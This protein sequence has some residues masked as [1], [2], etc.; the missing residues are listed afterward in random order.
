MTILQ[1]DPSLWRSELPAI[2]PKGHKYGRGIAVIYGAPK[3]TGA[4]RLAARA[5]ARIGAGLVKVIAPEGTGE[6]YRSTLSEEIIVEDAPDFQ[7]VNDARIRSVLLGPGLREDDVD[8]NAISMAL[9]VQTIGGIVL[10]AGA[11]AAWRGGGDLSRLVMTPHEGE[12]AARFGSLGGAS[13]V[14]KARAASKEA[15]SVILLKGAQT[16]IAGHGE[17]IVQD[18]DVPE[19]ATAGTG[20]VL[21]GMITGLIAQGMDT[22]FACAAAVWIHAEAASQFGRGMVASD[23]PEIIPVVMKRLAGPSHI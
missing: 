6:I 13:K 7:G 4:T 1:N 22:R 10:D 21:S 18:R 8:C 12:F 5:C 9:G 14:E 11:I 17:T 2:D 20:D 19:L 16:V 15:Q 23:L 3:M